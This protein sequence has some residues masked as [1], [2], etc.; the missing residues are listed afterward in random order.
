MEH[1]R[2]LGGEIVCGWE[3]K[4]L[5][6]LPKARAYLLDVAP[7]AV[8]GLAGERLPE[9]YLRRLGKYRFG[10]GVFKVDYALSSPIP[11]AAPEAREAGTVHV[12]GT[13]EEVADV[14]AGVLGGGGVGEAICAGGAAECV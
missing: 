2:S 13:F 12:G 9:R 14:R 10:P 7:P 4:S 6:E 1:L 8:V 3:V 5:S 11:W